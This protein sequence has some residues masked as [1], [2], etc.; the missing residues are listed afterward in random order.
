MKR[1]ITEVDFDHSDGEFLHNPIITPL[2]I[3]P[4]KLHENLHHFQHL[5]D[6]LHSFFK[7]DKNIITYLRSKTELKKYTDYK[8]ND[9]CKAQ[10]VLINKTVKNNSICY[11]CNGSHNMC[12]SFLSHTLTLSNNIKKGKTKL[13][14]VV[15]ESCM[16]FFTQTLLLSSHYKSIIFILCAIN[17]NPSAFYQTDVTKYILSFML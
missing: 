17:D 1:P 4:R 8:V 5:N 10:A 7:S 14:Y 13:L 11:F 15:N 6:I 12:H 2:R 3:I 9:L 16:S